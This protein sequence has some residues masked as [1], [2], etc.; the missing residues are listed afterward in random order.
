MTTEQLEKWMTNTDLARMTEKNEL[1]ARL[2]KI[3]R[4]LEL[5]TTLIKAFQ[6]TCNDI[7]ILLKATVSDT[8]QLQKQLQGLRN[9][10]DK[11]ETAKVNHE[12]RLTELENK[13][14]IKPLEQPKFTLF[15][16]FKRK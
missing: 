13:P 11:H 1:E 12:S 6:D 15:D 3:E 5:K 16:F 10:V 8:V 2:K 9:L 14:L 7:N 4:D